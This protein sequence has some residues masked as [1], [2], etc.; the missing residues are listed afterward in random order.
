VTN[1]TAFG[2]FIDLGVHKDGLLHKN[3]IDPGKMKRL[4]PGFR[5]MVEV[6]DVDESRGRISLAPAKTNIENTQIVAVQ[7]EA[8][9]DA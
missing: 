5:L 2:V 7:C 1:V 9:H 4:F 6:L 8:R 3:R